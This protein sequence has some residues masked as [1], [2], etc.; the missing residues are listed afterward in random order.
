MCR[1][2]PV[3]FL[4]C[5]GPGVLAGHDNRVSCIGVSSDGMACCTG[6]WDS[7]LKIWNWGCSWA[8]REQY[9]SAWEKVKED[10]KKKKKKR[11]WSLREGWGTRS[12]IGWEEG[13]LIV[14]SPIYCWRG[15]CNV[16]IFSSLRHIALSPFFSRYGGIWGGTRGRGSQKR[17]FL[18]IVTLRFNICTFIAAIQRSPEENSCQMEMVAHWMR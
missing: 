1:L 8:G 2:H 14:P 18:L 9:T 4:P 6:S 13:I 16:K 17:S 12:H 11:N 5:G 7:F 10:L 3:F 15:G